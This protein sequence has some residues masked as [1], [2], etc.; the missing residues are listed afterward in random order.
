M[1][2][3]AA[4]GI[5][6]YCSTSDDPLDQYHQV[7][8]VELCGAYIMT[9]AQRLALA[10]MPV[11]QL[12]ESENGEVRPRN[13]AMAPVVSCHPAV[14]NIREGEP[15]Q[16]Y[17]REL[18]TTERLHLHTELIYDPDGKQVGRLLS[19]CVHVHDQTGVDKENNIECAD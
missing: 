8:V 16:D 7:P 19:K 13:Q 1:M 14:Q 5:R 12:Y 17:H 9:E 3:C 11:L 2:A 6:T 4:C 18:Q 10:D 15:P